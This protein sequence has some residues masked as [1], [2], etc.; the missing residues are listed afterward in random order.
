MKKD[1]IKVSMV[2]EQEAELLPN[3]CEIRF[4]CN[5]V[6]YEMGFKDMGSNFFKVEKK[7]PPQ[8]FKSH[9]KITLEA[10]KNCD[11]YAL[12]RQLKQMLYQMEEHIKRHDCKA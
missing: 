12:G 2:S 4:D 5:V 8:W 3:M 6:M 11:E 10:I 1:E 7:Q 9:A